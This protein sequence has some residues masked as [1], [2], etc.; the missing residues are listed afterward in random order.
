MTS[1]DKVEGL[2]TVVILN[3]ALSDGGGDSSARR[4]RL[5]S[6]AEA[7][8]TQRWI[9]NE[10]LTHLSRVGP[11]KWEMFCFLQNNFIT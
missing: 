2:Q 7:P 9:T 11:Q 8:P 1:D 10:P 3:A 6:S 5:Q 4:G